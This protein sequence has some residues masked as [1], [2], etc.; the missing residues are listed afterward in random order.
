MNCPIFKAAPL[1]L[2]SLSTS[3]LMFASLI[4]GEAFFP[5]AGSAERNISDAAPT[6]KEAARPKKSYGFFLL[7]RNLVAP[8]KGNPSTYCRNGKDGPDEMK[9]L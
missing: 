2:L 4:K 9:A 3:L 5:V 1:I 8:A 7:R 6:D